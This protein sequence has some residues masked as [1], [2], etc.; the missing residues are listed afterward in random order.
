MWVEGE[1]DHLPCA[2]ARSSG[3]TGLPVVLLVRP[4]GTTGLPVARLDLATLA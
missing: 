2:Y 3:I 1:E 4:A